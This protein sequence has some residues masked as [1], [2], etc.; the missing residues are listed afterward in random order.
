MDYQLRKHE[1]GREAIPGAKQRL[2]QARR[3]DQSPINKEWLYPTIHPHSTT[4]RINETSTR[5]KRNDNEALG[6][7]HIANGEVL[8]EDAGRREY[9]A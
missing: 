8:H 2:L 5:I 4:T 7:R 3:H 9:K 6:E 1:P